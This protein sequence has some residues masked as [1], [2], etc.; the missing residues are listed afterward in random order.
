MRTF[1]FGILHPR[2]T[3]LPQVCSFLIMKLH[4]AMP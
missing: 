3:E 2:E 4:H 1:S